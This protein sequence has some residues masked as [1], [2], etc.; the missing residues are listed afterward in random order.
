M[1]NPCSQ[2]IVKAMC[3]DKCHMLVNYLYIKRCR[4]KGHSIHKYD[5][6]MIPY[7]AFGVRNKAIT[8]FDLC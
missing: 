5:D 1:N 6:G 3:K 4:R 7:I 2:C 8:L